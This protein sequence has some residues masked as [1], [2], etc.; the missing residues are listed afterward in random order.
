MLD[1]EAAC[2]WCSHEYRIG[3]Y[4]PETET[5]HLLECPDYPEDA[6]RRMRKRKDA[7]P[8]EPEVGN[9][10]PRRRETSN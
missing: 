4:S 6:K 1:V 2:F 5:G 9:Y 3:E 7:K 8:T 10:L